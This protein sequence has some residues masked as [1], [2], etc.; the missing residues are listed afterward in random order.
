[1]D[2]KGM[3]VANAGVLLELWCFESF[4]CCHKQNREKNP[5][6]Y[7]GNRAKIDL[8]HCVLFWIITVFKLVRGRGPISK[9]FV[10]NSKI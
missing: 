7:V 6:Q 2:V 3:G 10:H 1:M 5:T 8:L 4:L 9:V